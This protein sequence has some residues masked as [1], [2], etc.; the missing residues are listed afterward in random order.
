VSAGFE[1]WVEDQVARFRE[2]AALLARH[3]AKEAAETAEALA[4]DLEADFR[5]WW[6]EELSVTDAA[7]ECGYSEERLREMV[8][9]RR[10]EGQRNG[11]RGAIRV[12]RRDLPR[13]ATGGKPDPLQGVAARLGIR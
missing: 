3:G 9:E 13:K 12:R 11:D 4:A 1:G 5:L 2:R 7:A 8:R 10:V 6:L